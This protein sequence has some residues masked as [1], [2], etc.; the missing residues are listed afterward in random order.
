MP[1]SQIKYNDSAFIE[2]LFSEC[3]S[4]LI[5]KRHD[6]AAANDPHIN[7]KL[8]AFFA[9]LPVD[10]VYQVMIGI[11]VTRLRQLSDNPEGPKHEPF[12]DTIKDLMNY[13]ALWLDWRQR[14]KNGLD[15]PIVSAPP[16]TL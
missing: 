2:S 15:H 5:S 12:E 1:E 16:M 6:Y 8:T 3:A 14:V 9:G 13:C 10:K 11:K 7:F 4:L